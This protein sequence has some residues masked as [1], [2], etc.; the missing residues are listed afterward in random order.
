MSL[1]KPSTIT[2]EL[3]AAARGNSL[4]STGPRS[5]AAKQN[6]KLNALKHAVYLSPENDRQA[7]Q[8][9]G[10]DPKAFD[11]LRQE[12][13]SA[14]SP[15]DAFLEKQ[16]DDLSWLYWRRDRSERMLSGLRRQALEAVEERQR[17]RRREMAAVTF[18]PSRHELLD[19]D[20]T[21]S[22]DRGAALRL[23]LSYLGVLRDEVRQG[24]HRQR[25]GAVL[26]SIYPAAKAWRPQLIYALWY[27][28]W[29]AQETAEKAAKDPHYL[30]CQRALKLWREPPG[31]AEQQEYVKLLEEEI[32]AVEE[33]LGEEEKANERRA[34]IERD[35]CLA[36]QGPAW[37]ALVRQEGSLDR[38]IDRKVRI[39]LKLRN[40]AARL[41]SAAAGGDERSEREGLEE[42]A[43]PSAPEPAEVVPALANQKM[44]ERSGNVI[45]N[46]GS[47]L[48]TTPL[49]STPL[50]LFPLPRGEGRGERG[51]RVRGASE[52]LGGV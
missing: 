34:A 9:L 32:A 43:N 37:T 5:P 28:F 51:D 25:H 22:E 38:S 48:E 10:E 42:V 36:P 39:L 7:M 49:T 29:K 6:S 2:P 16:V 44:Q 1:R 15:A 3:L 19:W 35:A 30:D 50:P 4:H 12:L 26:E 40:D 24:I 11:A 18:D 17:R 33:E 23:R 45:E 8:S 14:F 46:K 41:A 21:S 47:D 27:R 20:L 52:V 13:R 31:E